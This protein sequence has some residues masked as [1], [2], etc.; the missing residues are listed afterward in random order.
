LLD[1][2]ARAADEGISQVVWGLNIVEMPIV[3]QLTALD[4]AAGK[5]F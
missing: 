1:D 5:I 2:L 4:R 3:D